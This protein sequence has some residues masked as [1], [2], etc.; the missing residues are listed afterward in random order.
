MSRKVILLGEAGVGKSA[1]VHFCTTGEFQRKYIPTVGVNYTKHA[2]LQFWDFA[3]QEKFGCVKTDY[4]SGASVALI[5]MTTDD[6]TMSTAK[7]Y[8][9]E[10]RTQS[11]ETEIILVINN[12]TD[13]Q[14]PVPTS[15]WVGG[16]PYFFVC[17]KN[18]QGC[19]Q[20]LDVLAAA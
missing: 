7:N 14:M 2:G 20:V 12:K 11:P 1:F 5:L 10:I 6:Y 18:G 8:I 3:G 4:F 19:R 15:G 17:V 13:Q 16:L 9:T